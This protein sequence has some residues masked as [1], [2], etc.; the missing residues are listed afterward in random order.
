M[1]NCILICTNLNII[2]KDNDHGDG[3][4][5]CAQVLHRVLSRCVNS[6]IAG[7][8]FPDSYLD[9]VIIHMIIND[10]DKRDIIAN[11]S[12]QFTGII[13]FNPYN[14]SMGWVLLYKECK[15]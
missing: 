15:P 10:E 11:P 13:S 7:P 4:L 2:L 12:K 5:L 1:L 8:G 3:C 9:H 14:N 6:Q